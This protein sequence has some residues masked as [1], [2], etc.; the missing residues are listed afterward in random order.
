MRY[1][2]AFIALVLITA[3]VNAQSYSA[4]K[5][6]R[7]E[8]TFGTGVTNFL[9]DLGGADQIGTDFYKDVELSASR[10]NAFIGGRYKL[11]PRQAIM[12]GFSWGM[13]AGDD[14]TTNWPDRLDRRFKFRSNVIE[15]GARY[16]F[17][18]VRE[19]TGHRYKLKKIKGLKASATYPYLFLGVAGFYHNPYQIDASGKY[20]R[21]RPLNTEGQTLVATRKPFSPFGLAI[22]YGVGFRWAVDKRWMIGIEWGQR[23]TFTDYM[24]GVSTTYFD[25][26][27][28]KSEFGATAA[29]LADPNLGS[30]PHYAAGQQRGDPTDNDSYGFLFITAS[31]KL[32]TT[33]GGGVRF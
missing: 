7:A 12:V 24:D 27:T 17:Y 20:H 32:K 15:L 4:W 22:P 6:L 19:K 11:D 1:R 2:I 5:R 31:Y 26:N 21:I 10:P 18:F 3:G 30:D 14:K 33:R 8:M 29:Y 9:G 16:E 28:I 25:N 23:K 13:L